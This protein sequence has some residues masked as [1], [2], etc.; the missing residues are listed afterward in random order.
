MTVWHVHLV[1]AFGGRESQVEDA[2]EAVGRAGSGRG[3]SS[4]NQMELYDRSFT[5]SRASTTPLMC[6]QFHGKS[7]KL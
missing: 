3:L 5:S 6:L 2:E 1:R 7:P 4:K